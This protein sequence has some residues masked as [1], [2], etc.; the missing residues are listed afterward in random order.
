MA[1]GSKTPPTYA[2]V[3][4]ITGDQRQGKS[5][6]LVAYPVD[7]YY[8]NL[9]AI[10]AP[11]GLRI[12]AKSVSKGV[13]PADNLLLRR[14]GIVPSKFKYVRVFSED[15]RQ[16]K[17]ITIP[18]GYF[19]DSPV[20]IFANFTLFGISFV[21]I[22]LDDVIRY[23]D[24][25]LFN[26]A[27]VLSDESAMTDARNSMTKAGILM[28]QFGATV[29]KRNAHFCVAAQYLEQ[30]ER[31]FRLFATTT[32][33]CTYDEDTQYVTVDVTRRGEKFT[34]DFYQ[35][36]Y[37]PFYKTQE[38]IAS[39]QHQID[40]ALGDGGNGDGSLAK[41]LA[42]MKREYRR[43]EKELADA[44]DANLVLRQALKVGV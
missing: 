32:I 24:T 37:R 29:G 10:V 30:I 28:A 1:D 15:E 9:N 8:N 40:R 26:D 23:K 6:V 38:L 19:V 25:P 11:N 35:P 21:K 43:L 33:S 12:K 14:A 34:T 44:E 4:I 3:K 22:S 7:D 13:N 39:P 18:K 2:D 31:R 27:W 36:L 20:K 42:K 17:L 16:S 41:K 5:T